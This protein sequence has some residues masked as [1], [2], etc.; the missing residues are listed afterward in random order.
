MDENFVSTDGIAH[1]FQSV[2][3]LRGK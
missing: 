3:H 1:G 2:L